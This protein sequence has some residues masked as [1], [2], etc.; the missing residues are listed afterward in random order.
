MNHVDAD[1]RFEQ[2]AG[3]VSGAAGAG[4]G[5]GDLAQ[6]CEFAGTLLDWL[7]ASLVKGGR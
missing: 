5:H 6:G 2:L 1:Q 3:D 7:T 4:R